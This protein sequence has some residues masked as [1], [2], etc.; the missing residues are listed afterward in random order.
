MHPA[1]TFQLSFPFGWCVLVTSAR[2]H[3]RSVHRFTCIH[4]TNYLALSRSV[5]I[6]RVRFSR[7]APRPSALLH[8]QASSLFMA[9]GS[10]GSTSGSILRNSSFRRPRVARRKVQ[11]VKTTNLSHC[12][13]RRP[14]EKSFFNQAPPGRILSR[15][16][17]HIDQAARIKFRAYSFVFGFFMRLLT[18][19][20]ML[21]TFPR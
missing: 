14:V 21:I 18:S 4:H 20:P 13:F 19:F 9:I 17:L 15:I 12:I 5:T 3:S 8:C 11:F 10:L 7:F 16:W 2:L 6:R 1:I